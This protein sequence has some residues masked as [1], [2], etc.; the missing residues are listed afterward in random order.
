MHDRVGLGPRRW[1]PRVGGHVGHGEQD[2]LATED[3]LVAGECLA[4]V[5]GEGEVWTNS[6]SFISLIVGPGGYSHRRAEPRELIDGLPGR[7]PRASARPTCWSQA[8]ST[9]PSTA[10]APS[11]RS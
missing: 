6:H 3:V 5:A 11:A 9:S 10:A 7:S 2:E 1:R 8:S 4:A